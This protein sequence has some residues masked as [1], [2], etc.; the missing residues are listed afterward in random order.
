MNVWWKDRLLPSVVHS[1]LCGPSK[2]YPEGRQH[3]LALELYPAHKNPLL[4]Y[5]LA[6]YVDTVV[7][8]PHSF[9]HLLLSV[10]RKVAQVLT[11]LSVWKAGMPICVVSHSTVKFKHGR[12]QDWSQTKAL[13][14]EDTGICILN[15]CLFIAFFSRRMFVI[16]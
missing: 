9:A 13:T 6:L 10:L 3:L 15:P 16:I 14:T 4:I 7:L 11:P 5:Q 8:F 12:D 1:S 2:P